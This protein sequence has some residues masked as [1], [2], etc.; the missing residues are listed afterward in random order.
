MDDYENT[1]AELEQ[2]HYHITNGIILR[3]KVKWYEE[4]E[5]NNKY[6]FV[7]GKTKQNEI[8]SES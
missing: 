1:K 2:I 6:F 5:K 3:S 8:T 4:G 7:T